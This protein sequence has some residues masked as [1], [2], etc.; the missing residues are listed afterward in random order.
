MLSG[1]VIPRIWMHDDFSAVQKMAPD[2]ILLEPGFSYLLFSGFFF[3]VSCSRCQIRALSGFLACFPKLEMSECIISASLQ[4]LM[5]VMHITDTT[6]LFGLRPDY[7]RL[8][9]AKKFA[10][11][12]SGS[13]FLVS[14]PT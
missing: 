9:T 14:Q 8:A 3:L 4:M 7:F 6:H 5:K 2:N 10:K 13:D 12:Q 11:M 1:I